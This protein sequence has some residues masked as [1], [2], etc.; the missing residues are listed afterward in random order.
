M[1]EVPQFFPQA[2]PGPHV[3]SRFCVCWRRRMIDIP[4]KVCEY[5]V[6][7]SS[8]IKYGGTAEGVQAAALRPSPTVS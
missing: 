3:N 2:S 8:S 6:R 1:Y 7:R 4:N 5:Q